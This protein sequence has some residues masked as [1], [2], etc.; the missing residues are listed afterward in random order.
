[1]PPKTQRER[2]AEQREAKLERIQEQ[3]EAGSLVIRTMTDAERERFAKRSK[4]TEVDRAQRTQR[5]RTRAAT[6]RP[7]PPVPRG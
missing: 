3:V 5:R 2:E 7:L 1:M 6:A 4:R